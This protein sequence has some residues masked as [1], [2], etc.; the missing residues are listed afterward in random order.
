MSINTFLLSRKDKI[1]RLVFDNAHVRYGDAISRQ[2]GKLVVHAEVPEGDDV[3]VG[4]FDVVFDDVGGGEV[5]DLLLAFGF[6]ADFE[7][8][9]A[10]LEVG[11]G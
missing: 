10:D 2:I 8:A 7:C 6:A 1:L 9:V 5:G 4:G 11:G 3:G